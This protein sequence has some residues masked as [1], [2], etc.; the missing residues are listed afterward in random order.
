MVCLLKTEQFQILNEQ[1][2]KLACRVVNDT[3]HPSFVPD[4]D[5]WWILRYDCLVPVKHLQYALSF[6][7][8]TLT[9]MR[10]RLDPE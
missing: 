4:S 10:L 1:G 2:H 5:E 6:A 9:F 3:K 8:D 7:N